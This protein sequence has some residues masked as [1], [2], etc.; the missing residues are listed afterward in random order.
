MR[1]E[2]LGPTGLCG[3]VRAGGCIKTRQVNRFTAA[4]GS[5]LVYIH[6]TSETCLLKSSGL[7]VVVAFMKHHCTN[8][9]MKQRK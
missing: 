3:Q 9:S 4:K 7:S 8:I 2:H 6:Q 1:P 5:A